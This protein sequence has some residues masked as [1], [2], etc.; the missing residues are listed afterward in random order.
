MLSILFQLA[1]VTATDADFPTCTVDLLSFEP[2]AALPGDSITLTATPLTELQDSSLRVGGVDAAITSVDR[3]DCET[4][5]SCRTSNGCASCDQ[6]CDA[7]DA[8]CRDNCVETLVFTLPQL[9][10]GSHGVVLFNAH[11][12]SLEARIEVL[13]AGVDTGPDTG[14]QDS[15]AD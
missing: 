13:E 5:D 10:A 15:G 7:C 8:E 3:T 14:G 11:G 4:C 2:A 6:D 12:G 9:D 1:C